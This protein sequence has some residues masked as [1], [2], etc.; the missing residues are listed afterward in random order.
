MSIFT[1]IAFKNFE[2]LFFT[3]KKI[4]AEVTFSF[5]STLCNPFR[6]ISE[7][8]LA[9]LFFNQKMQGKPWKML[10]FASF[11]CVLQTDCSLNPM[12]LEL[13]TLIKPMH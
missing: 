4:F 12:L 7:F 10:Y 6:P 8:S 5:V 1:R 11:V 13:R 9:T 3:F 2:K